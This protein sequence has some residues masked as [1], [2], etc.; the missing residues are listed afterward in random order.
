MQKYLIAMTAAAAAGLGYGAS[1]LLSAQSV[2]TV[3]PQVVSFTLEAAEVASLAPLGAKLCEQA[4][5]AYALSPGTCTI[6]AIKQRTSGIWIK[7]IPE[8]TQPPAEE[9]GD[10]VVV[11]A[12]WDMGAQFRLPGSFVAD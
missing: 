10:P 4:D 2:P 9:G 6:A 11:P 5:A 7:W 1:N 3:H 8:T 12:H